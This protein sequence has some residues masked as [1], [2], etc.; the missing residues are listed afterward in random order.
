[1]KIF[2]SL[3]LSSRSVS[4]AGRSIRSGYRLAMVFSSVSS[5][6]ES[7]VVSGPI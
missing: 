4:N 5:A 2:V 6:L 1:M 3:I 7:T